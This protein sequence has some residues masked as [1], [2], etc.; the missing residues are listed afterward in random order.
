MNLLIYIDSV[1]TFTAYMKVRAY[2]TY[3]QSKE[4]IWIKDAKPK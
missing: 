2:T 3:K 4:N 1:K